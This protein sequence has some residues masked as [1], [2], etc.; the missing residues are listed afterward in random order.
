MKTEKTK[1]VVLV[2][3]SLQA[4]GMERAMSELAIYFAA[5]THIRLHLLLYG[6]KREI[7]YTIPDNISIHKP[8][9]VFNNSIRFISTVRTFFFLRKK[10]G[11]LQPDAVLSFGEYWNSFVLL[12]CIGLKLPIYVSDRCQPDKNLGRMQEWLR[13]WLYPKAKGIIAQ[14]QIA[15]DIYLSNIKQPNVQVIANP[16]RL[17]EPNGGIQKENIVLTIGRLIKTKHHDKLIE[18]FAKIDKP[19]WKLVIIGDDAFDQKSRARLQALINKLGVQDNIILAGKQQ[20]VDTYYLKSKVFVFSSSS[21]GFPNV[22]G[23]AQSAGLPVVAFDCVAGPA[24]M[25]TDGEN[26]FLVP[27]F[28]YGVF[29]NR[30]LQLMEDS[31]LRQRLGENAKQ[32]IKKFSAVQTVVLFENFILNPE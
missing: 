20:D 11:S 15:K 21:E 17:V 22:I 19:G 3:P 30:L 23:E 8:A 29:E 4:G 18:L 7:F 24:E 31:E 14:T 13:R 12:S 28:D 2:I 26:G 32:S 27:L 16:I 10:L 6:I 9:F 5:R 25:I 1:T